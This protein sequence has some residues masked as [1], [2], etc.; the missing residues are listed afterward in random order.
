[1]LLK[2]LND[3]LME[4]R[5]EAQ[6]VALLVALW[7]GADQQLVMA[8]AGA[9]P[10]L[11]CR[12]GRLLRPRPVGMPLGMMSN[13]EYE[14]L[15]VTIEVGDV[16]LFYSDGYEDQ[17]NSAGEVY[18]QDRLP[19]ALLRLAVRPAEEIAAGLERELDE[20]RGDCRVHDDQ[21]LLVLKVL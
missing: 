17:T 11:I 19:A 14:E 6:Y 21:T 16:I 20:F 2:T 10:P 3:E 7:T 9:L 12:K 1:M 15:A 13:Q 5:V 18:G 4:R 8:N